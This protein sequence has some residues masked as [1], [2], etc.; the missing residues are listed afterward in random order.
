MAPFYPAY[1]HEDIT[2]SC[3]R[4]RLAEAVIF[5]DLEV[6]VVAFDWGTMSGFSCRT[7]LQ[8]WLRWRH[9]TVQY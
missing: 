4:V 1:G 2:S 5:N 6:E 7:Y 3:R 9:C 8:L